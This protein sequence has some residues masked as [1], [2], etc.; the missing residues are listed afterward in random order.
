M[1][2]DLHNQ[3]Y[4]KSEEVDWAKA[5]LPVRDPVKSWMRQPRG[6]AKIAF[7]EISSPPDPAIYTEI[8]RGPPPAY[9][10]VFT[11]ITPGETVKEMPLGQQIKTDVNGY[12]RVDSYTGQTV[13]ISVP[14]EG[15]YVGEGMDRKFP[16]FKPASWNLKLLPG[17]NVVTVYAQAGLIE[18]NGSQMVIPDVTHDYQPMVSRPSMG[19]SVGA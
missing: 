16:L 6:E 19:R 10:D 9:L 17:R 8:P 4:G 12:T 14:R 5:N 18:F 7:K 2:S 11:I 13:M 3:K 15:G 1:H